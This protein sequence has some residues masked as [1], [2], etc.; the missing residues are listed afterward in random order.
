MINAVSHIQ[1]FL[2]FLRVSS[3]KE[4][5]IQTLD[6]I[7]FKSSF[8]MKIGKPA[9]SYTLSFYFSNPPND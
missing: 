7:I 6:F 3:V 9:T 4:H 2:L 8:L 1:L 5:L